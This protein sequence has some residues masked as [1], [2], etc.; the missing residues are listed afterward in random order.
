MVAKISVFDPPLLRT[1]ERG[2]FKRC[3]WLWWQHWVEGVS[4]LRAPTW[5]VFG[6]AVHKA[7]E[8]RYRVGVKRRPMGEAIEVFLDF[9]DGEIRK[10]GV[11]IFEEEFEK[12]EAKAE[13]DGK[14]VKL[15]PAHE[16][17]EQMLLGY[18]KTYGPER[19]W[20]VLHT[21]QPFQI[22]VPHPTRKGETIVVYCGT[23]DALMRHR[24]SG[25]L[26]LWDHKTCRSFPDERYL[27]LNDQAGT[28]PWVAKEVL[29]HKGI[30]TKK[31]KIYGI[32][33]NYLKKTPPDERPTNSAGE[34]LNKDG[35]VSLRQPSPR[36]KR[37]ESVRT[38][39]M[40]VKQA[41]RVQ[42]E[43]LVMEQFRNGTLPIYKTTTQDCP[44]CI[45]YD[46]CDAEESGDD[47]E[48]I[49]DELYVVRDPYADHR[50]AMT[51]GGIEL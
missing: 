33:F 29:V 47:W 50:E 7:L 6:T 24:P 32:I 9:L 15:V 8:H 40:I 1:S 45:L 35:S 34:A 21:E 11:D 17:G 23:W 2:D 22:D 37:F 28:Y 43:A 36:F 46:M 49:R 26:W 27:G 18:E 12:K 16:L 25:R 13:A 44:R 10:I 41:R 30:L 39:E 3:P 4:P 48:L 20:E 31:D 51:E 38:S 19:D 42:S 14:T 5:S